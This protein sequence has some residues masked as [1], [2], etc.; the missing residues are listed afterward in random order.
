MQILSLSLSLVFNLLF[1]IIFSLSFTFSIKKPEPI[2]ISL[3]DTPI[4]N[5]NILKDIDFP[6][7]ETMREQE[8]ISPPKRDPAGLT[9]KKEDTMEERL[10]RN[11]I[12]ALRAQRERT[13]SQKVEDE[14]TYLS[15]RLSSLRDRVNKT[16]GSIQSVQS[17]P[18]MQAGSKG[19]DSLT[20]GAPSEQKL[21]SEHLFLVKRKLQ[22][23]FEI[24]IYLKNK[25]NLSALVEIEVKENGEIV[26][27]NFVRAS[28]DPAFNRAVENCLRAVN[29]L[30]VDRAVRLRIEFRTDGVG[31]IS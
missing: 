12:S 3:V 30:P 1:L 15:E 31:N 24:P 8:R 14:S 25:P 9:R 29:P 4:Q 20:K 27:I 17:S 19:V 18:T 7:R 23:H 13:I 21:P 16:Q 11:R 28:S 26:R 22:T 5:P 6:Q 2:L 10:L